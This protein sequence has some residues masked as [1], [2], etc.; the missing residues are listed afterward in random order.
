MT[1]ARTCYCKQEGCAL[2]EEDNDIGTRSENRRSATVASRKLI[3]KSGDSGGFSGRARSVVDERKSDTGGS[4]EA[5]VRDPVLSPETSTALE[6]AERII[7]DAKIQLAEVRAAS[8]LDSARRDI[9]T[10]VDDPPL[11]DEAEELLYI[12]EL[13]ASKFQETSYP[14]R[15]EACAEENARRVSARRVDLSAPKFRTSQRRRAAPLE[16][17][18]RGRAPSN[19]EATPC[20]SSTTYGVCRIQI[21]PSVHVSGELARQDLENVRVSPSPARQRANTAT[22]ILRHEDLAEESR[23]NEP[24]MR[25]RRRAR[26][27]PSGKLEGPIVAVENEDSGHENRQTEPTTWQVQEG[28]DLRDAED[29]PERPSATDEG[30][31]SDDQSEIH[32]GNRVKSRRSGIFNKKSGVDIPGRY[33]E[34]VADKI[35][36]DRSKPPPPG[37]VSRRASFPRRGNIAGSPGRTTLKQYRT[38][39]RCLSNTFAVE[40]TRRSR[41]SSDDFP[42]K[43][44]ASELYRP[45]FDQL[46][47]ILLSNDKK[48]ERLVRAAQSFAESLSKPEFAKY[49]FEEGKREPSTV[50]SSSGDR[51]EPLASSKPS[52]SV[53]N[54]TSKSPSRSV[55]RETSTTKSPGLSGGNVRRREDRSKNSAESTEGPASRSKS[56]SSSESSTNKSEDVSTFSNLLSSTRTDAQIAQAKR[57]ASADSKSRVTSRNVDDVFA[58]I[59]RDEST[60][61]FVAYILQEEKRSVEE[62]RVAKVLDESVIATV[63]KLLVRMREAEDDRATR[64]TETLDVPMD[65]PVDAKNR[66]DDDQV[67]SRSV[68]P[69]PLGDARQTPTLSENERPIETGHVHSSDPLP[70]RAE[71]RGSVRSATHIVPSC[72]DNS[73]SKRE[74]SEGD[75]LKRVSDIL[76]DEVG[77]PKENSRL[78]SAKTVAVGSHERE[79][80]GPATFLDGKSD[81]N[82]SAEVQDDQHTNGSVPR[83]TSTGRADDALLGVPDGTLVLAKEAG[84]EEKEIS[85]DNVSLKKVSVPGDQR[86]RSGLEDVVRSLIEESIESSRLPAGK[87]TRD[88]RADPAADGKISPVNSC[89]ADSLRDCASL[90]SLSSAQSDESPLKGARS[91]AERISFGVAPEDNST[92]SHNEGVPGEPATKSRGNGNEESAL[93]KSEPLRPA[94]LKS[95]SSVDDGESNNG[96]FNNDTKRFGTSSEM[97]HSEG[98]LYMPSSCSY[99]LGEVRI[100]EKSDLN[101][102]STIERESSVTILVT[103]SMLT[104]LNDSS[105]PLGTSGRI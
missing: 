36:G 103:R 56:R 72:R 28:V 102:N 16:W 53:E 67:D 12:R 26:L 39:D 37:D 54:T 98:E 49:K 13:V 35:R 38:I 51:E 79:V 20:D 52:P 78:S 46:D 80:G 33:E 91:R 8:G 76:S 41:L 21:G 34:Q 19:E 3:V 50:D 66:T 61:R 9:D 15:A 86:A 87:D 77:S 31:R 18:A 70:E 40:A 71:T 99:S 68:S 1:S 10:C 105:T 47:S 69:R 30:E 83:A 97:S 14:R 94:V 48:I 75:S 2:R 23:V 101:A 74:G 22:Y 44:D 24:A 7:N 43:D 6:N 84:E 95:L 25:P 29:A 93:P 42:A 85:A 63:E 82:E 89:S 59:L 60:D 5:R 92:K 55:S 65:I 57:S 17:R 27:S 11:D 58:R 88:P 32:L 62:G 45:R 81:V 104:S 100:L 64:R 90:R 4:I 96:A 73:E